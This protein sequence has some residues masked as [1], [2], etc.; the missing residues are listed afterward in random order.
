LVLNFK[1]VKCVTAHRRKERTMTKATLIAVAAVSLVTYNSSPSLGSAVNTVTADSIVSSAEVPMTKGTTSLS[2]NLAPN[3]QIDQIVIA[4]VLSYNGSKPTITAPDG[5]QLIRDDYS[6]TTRQSLYWHTVQANDP[7]TA[8]W[9]FS[10]PVDAQG[11]ILLLDNVASDSP[12]D[13]TSGS[14]GSVPTLT[15]KSIANAAA[16]DLILVFYATDFE[17]TGLAPTMPDEVDSVL[18]YEAPHEYW[19]L[20]NY[21]SQNGSTGDAACPTP[22]LFNWIAAQVAIKRGAATL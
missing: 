3:A 8:S 22:Q 21:Q 1:M 5:W 20:A 7:T 13:N 10:E 2:V 6:L 18:N 19:I 15:A 11:A 17:G 12:V 14:T 4:D 9:T 16:G